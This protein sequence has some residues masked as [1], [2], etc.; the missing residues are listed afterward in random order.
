MMKIRVL[1]F[2]LVAALLAAA[3]L[4]VRAAPSDD[5]EIRIG[6]DFA[7]Q[8]ESRYK[9]ITT[10]AILERVTRIGQEIAG[11]SDRSELP[12]TFKVVDLDLPN[13]V[14]LP[15]GFVYVT[16]GMLSFVR[17]DHELAAVLA[18]EIAHTAHHH[19]ME[20][21]RRS[22]LATF[23]TI[24]VAV[25]TRNPNL[26][27]GVQ[28]VSTAMLSGYT[29]ELERDADLTSIAYLAKTNY[30]PVA[31]LT[32]MERLLREE[33]LSPQTDPGD[34]R[35]HPRTEERVTYINAEL[36]RRGIPLVRRPA[37][38]YLRISTRTISDG[39]RL[40]AE[41]YVN[42]TPVLRLPDPALVTAAVAP[43][44]RFFNTDPDPWE[45]TAMPAG[46]AWEIAGGRI[47][48]F[49]VTRDAA[50]FLGVPLQEAALQIQARLRQVIVDDQRRRQ[51]NG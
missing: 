40:V 51:F 16:K 35:D 8:L 18:H 39:G 11:V 32:V 37:A 43:L 5:Q 6:R 2:I 22:N 46:E 1:S 50:A 30:T 13:A 4:P 21:I 23:W 10:R 47:V 7:R 49:R 27:Q 20:M 15:G 3:A 12:F 34:F 45:V 19:Q 44:D 42:D 38:N 25:L 31:A 48:L 29:R 9:L 28:L 36:V 41:L 14:A 33:R 26:A 24:L 17:S